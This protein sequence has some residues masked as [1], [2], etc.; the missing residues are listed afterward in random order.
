M[1]T[2]RFAEEAFAISE[3]IGV[4]FKLVLAMKITNVTK[5]A[6]NIKVNIFLYV[7][8]MLSDHDKIR[9]EQL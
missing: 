5:L 4:P 9:L 1:A 3:A 2:M 8:K 7:V 6:V